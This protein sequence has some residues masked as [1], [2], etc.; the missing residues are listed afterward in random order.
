[1]FRHDAK[2]RQQRTHHCIHNEQNT[3]YHMWCV[4]NL[5]III[6][7]RIWNISFVPKSHSFTTRTLSV[8]QTCYTQVL[9]HIASIRTSFN[10]LM[11]A[12]WIWITEG[13][14]LGSGGVH[15][16][17]M[18]WSLL[19]VVLYVL[20]RMCCFATCTR[21][22][23]FGCTQLQLKPPSYSPLTSIITVVFVFSIRLMHNC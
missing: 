5:K 6:P 21:D 10:G 9:L 3:K 11:V 13:D 2:S 22:F 15:Q 18:S 23:R 17:F 8:L 16:M 20:S 1:M 7:I 14:P 19:C 12:V 4:P